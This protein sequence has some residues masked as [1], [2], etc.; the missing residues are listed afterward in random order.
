V[1]KL[2]FDCSSLNRQNLRL[3]VI[4][5]DDVGARARSSKRVGGAAAFD[6]DLN[7]KAA[8]G[9]RGCDCG[10]NAARCGDVVVLQH[11]LRAPVTQWQHAQADSRS[12]W[13]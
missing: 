5:H 7:T 11:D 4:E 2:S 8:Q 3:K 10:R 13:S 12:P 9:A 6:L 1:W